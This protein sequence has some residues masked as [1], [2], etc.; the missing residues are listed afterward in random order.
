M[1]LYTLLYRMNYEGDNF[2]GVYDSFE[3]AKLSVD[4]KE[5][6]KVD[7]YSEGWIIEECELNKRLW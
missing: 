7:L 5:R 6:D 3:K 4:E 1:K 2:H